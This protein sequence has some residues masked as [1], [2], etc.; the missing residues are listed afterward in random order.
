LKSTVLQ[1]DEGKV[2]FARIDCDREGTVFMTVDNSSCLINVSYVCMHCVD[3]CIS[4]SSVIMLSL[5]ATNNRW[6]S[7]W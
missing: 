2:T 7:K 4:L 5:C 6:P 1:Q 3:T